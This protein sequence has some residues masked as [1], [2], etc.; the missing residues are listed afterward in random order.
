MPRFCVKQGKDVEALD[1]YRHLL[2]KV[3]VERFDY[4]TIDWNLDD[5]LSKSKAHF[6]QISIGQETE[7]KAV[8]LDVLLE[9]DESVKSW[10]VANLDFPW[11]SAKQIRTVVEG[12]CHRLA[13]WKGKLNLLK[14]PLRERIEGFIRRN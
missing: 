10:L 11:Y 13:K 7:Q 8:D 9:G 6:W 2:A 12:V 5:E 4:D 1:Y 14:F 3:N